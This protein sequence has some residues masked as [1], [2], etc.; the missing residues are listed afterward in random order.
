MAD[1]VWVSPFWHRLT[2][3][4]LEDDKLEAACGIWIPHEAATRPDPEPPVQDRCPVCDAKE[5]E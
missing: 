3:T 2:G 5:A 1:W 4:V